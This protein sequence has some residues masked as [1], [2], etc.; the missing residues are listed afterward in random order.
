MGAV[1]LRRIPP[2][3]HRKAI[4]AMG[5]MLSRCPEAAC[6][7]QKKRVQRNCATLWCLFPPTWMN[8]HRFLG[9]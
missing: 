8:S 1:S 3:P 2:S 4:E 7:P 9:F 6:S 5:I